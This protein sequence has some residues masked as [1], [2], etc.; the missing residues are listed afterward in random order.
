[1]V[2]LKGGK[3]EQEEGGRE[4]EGGREGGREGGKEEGE[5]GEGGSYT[6]LS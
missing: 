1:M 4:K 3:G 6:C 5:G 2:E